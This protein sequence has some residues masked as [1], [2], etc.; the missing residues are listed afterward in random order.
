[1]Q[2]AMLNDRKSSGDT[3]WV[4]TSIFEFWLHHPGLGKLLNLF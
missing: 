2:K 1:M 3:F 4:L